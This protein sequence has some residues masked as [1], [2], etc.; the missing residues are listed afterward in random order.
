MFYSSTAFFAKGL[1]APQI[2]M[3]RG[4]VQSTAVDYKELKHACKMIYAGVPS[5]I[6]LGIED[7]H[8][9]IAG[10]C[11]GNSDHACDKALPGK[12]SSPKL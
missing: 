12:P 9:P 10:F 7:G 5:L 3:V 4:L 8:L 2:L 6:G 1:D 11:C